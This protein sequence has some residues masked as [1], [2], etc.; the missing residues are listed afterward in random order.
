M[1]EPLTFTLYPLGEFNHSTT[2]CC[3]CILTPQIS[4]S[5]RKAQSQPGNLNYRTQNSLIP[6]SPEPITV[7]MRVLDPNLAPPSSPLAL[8][9]VAIFAATI[10]RRYGRFKF[11][12]SPPGWLPIIGHSHLF[13]IKGFTGDKAKAWGWYIRH[14]ISLTQG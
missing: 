8:L 6:P 1:L 10:F 11:P 5:T 13:P 3:Y 9:L 4:S 12:P 7:N 14:D 2:P